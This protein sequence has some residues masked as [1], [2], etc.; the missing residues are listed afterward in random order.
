MPVLFGSLF[1]L[2]L[3]MYDILLQQKTIIHPVIRILS[4][5][6]LMVTI[7]TAVNTS[8]KFAYFTHDL[9]LSK[10]QKTKQNRVPSQI[11]GFLNLSFMMTITSFV[12]FLIVKTV[13]LKSMTFFFNSLFGLTASLLLSLVFYLMLLW[14]SFVL[15]RNHI[16]EKIPDEY[17]SFWGKQFARMQATSQKPID[18]ASTTAQS[19]HQGLN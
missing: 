14:S 13:V 18:M 1:F 6:L 8:K 17:I 2:L 10:Q 4:I 9:K 7:I 12:L 5:L 16:D 15:I 11:H 3:P 19:I